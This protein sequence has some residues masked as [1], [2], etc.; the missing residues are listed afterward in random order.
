MTM[1]MRVI[2]DGFQRAGPLAAG[3]T[4]RT[5]GP[6]ARLFVPAKKE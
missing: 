5:I 3:G 2:F 6:E 1:T 4:L